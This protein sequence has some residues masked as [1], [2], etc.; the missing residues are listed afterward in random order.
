MFGPGRS[1]IKAAAMP[2]FFNDIP[3]LGEMKK[4]VPSSPVKTCT[5]ESLSKRP[6]TPPSD[7]PSSKK[8]SRTEEE[9][10]EPSSSKIQKR[11]E[12]EKNNLDMRRVT[13]DREELNEAIDTHSDKLRELDRIEEELAK[14]KEMLSSAEAL[15][16]ESMR[17]LDEL[18]KTEAALLARISELERKSANFEVTMAE[19]EAFRT[20]IADSLGLTKK[21]SF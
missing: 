10:A 11:D 4:T 21:E 6:R 14:K 8:R 9:N 18:E 7:S 3:G 15:I 20:K 19:V 12:L 2:K 5:L 16:D 17:Q 1:S 13:R